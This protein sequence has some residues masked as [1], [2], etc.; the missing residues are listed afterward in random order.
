[1]ST[2]RS[3][4][5][6][7]SQRTPV[8]RSQSADLNQANELKKKVLETGK[9]FQRLDQKPGV[10]R[11]SDKDTVYVNQPTDLPPTLGNKIAQVTLG[12]MAPK[13]EKALAEG[14]ARSENGELKTLSVHTESKE[15][16]KDFRY[17]KMDDGTEVFHGPTGDGRFMMVRENKAAGT[18]FVAT[19]IESMEGSFGSVSSSDFRPPETG[20]ANITRKAPER[21]P[22]VLQAAPSLISRRGVKA[23]ELASAN[24]AAAPVPAH[25]VSVE[26]GDITQVKADAL[27]TPI[28]SGGVWW[29]AID[30]AIQRT[31]GSQFHNQA[32]EHLGSMEDGQTIVANKK[33]QH[34][35]GFENVVFVVD[36]YQKPL[37]EIV[38]TGLQAADKAGMKTVSLPAMRMG[39]AA[40]AFE[41]TPE[42][43]LSQLAK[44]VRDF[45]A[46]GSPQNL[47]KIVISAYK[48]PTSAEFLRQQLGQA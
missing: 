32:R 41:K 33:E 35:G 46:E 24:A 27:L 34:D 7:P 11:E 12:F 18:L 4:I 10:D 38:K 9:R 39:V 16:V 20:P 3:F 17:E 29:G 37:S 28:N 42:E 47:D 13:Q 1:L 21:A 6:I 2:L 36:D 45:Y 14:Y 26:T 30:G 23:K 22:T 44:G 8:T 48:D 25:Q 15:G 19:D 40:G 31:G 5:N 43:T